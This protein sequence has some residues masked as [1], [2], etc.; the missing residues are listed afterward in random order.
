MTYV[1]LVITFLFAG[2]DAFA[3]DY[4]QLRRDALT[5]YDKGHYTQ[6]EALIRKS[7][8][9][10][11]RTKDEYEVALGY[12]AFGDISQA[13]LRLPEAEQAYRKAISILSQKPEYDRALAILWRNLASA[14]VSENRCDDATRAVSEGLKLAAKEKPEDPEMNAELLNSLGVIQFCQGKLNKAED[15]FLRAAAQFRVNPATSHQ[16]DLGEVLNN[17]GYVYQAK[18]QTRKAEAAYEQSLQ[19]SEL[20]FGSSHLRLAAPLQN[21]ATLY[22]ETGDY[23]RAE[24]NFQRSLAILEEEEAPFNEASI[25][26][27][28]YGLAK[29]YIRQNDEKR[30]D[31]PL[32][33][34]AAIA[35]KLK[36]PGSMPEALEILETY[37]QVL[38]HLANHQEAQLVQTE[39]KRMRATMA[40]TVSTPRAQ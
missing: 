5:E 26:H 39:A 30:S 3:D 11:Q 7:L 4:V 17:L 32:A 12:S 37:S 29:L 35:R 19:V 10:A 31:A 1:L 36:M 23:K 40:F 13:E 28:L 20:R 15:T 38:A 14:L 34:A 8:D 6:A 9:W 18:R 2:I 22:T 25:M 27:A 33:R 16:A 24:E 21:L